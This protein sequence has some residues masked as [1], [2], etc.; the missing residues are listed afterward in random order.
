MSSSFGSLTAPPKQIPA[1]TL[2]TVA[3]SIVTGN[4]WL[5]Y[6]IFAVSGGSDIAVT[7][8]DGRGKTLIP[9]YSF[10]HGVMTPVAIPEGGIFCA[11]GVQWSAASN[12]VVDGWIRVRPAQ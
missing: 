9:A 8:T 1:T 10:P 12:S 2:T 7:V 5:E 3:T 6:L 11:G 4:C